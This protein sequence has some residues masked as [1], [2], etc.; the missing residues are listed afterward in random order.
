MSRGCRMM[1]QSTSDHK[2]HWKIYAVDEHS[3]IFRSMWIEGF[4]VG[5]QKIRK[6]FTFFIWRDA[7]FV[8]SYIDRKMQVEFEKIRLARIERE[9]FLTICE[10]F[11]AR[12]SS[13]LTAPSVPP[14]VTA[15]SLPPGVKPKTRKL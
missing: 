6:E 10:E 1:P 4:P 11:S 7:D 9:K 8:S 5:H 15:P 3:F 14:A 13:L 2:D 12:K